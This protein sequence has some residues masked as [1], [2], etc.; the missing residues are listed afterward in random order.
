MSLCQ[1]I[2]VLIA[3]FSAADGSN[4]WGWWVLLACLID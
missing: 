3:C 2:L 1:L 4:H